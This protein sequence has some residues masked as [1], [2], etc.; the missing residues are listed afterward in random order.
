[1]ARDIKDV[2]IEKLQLTIEQKEVIKELFGVDLPYQVTVL[3]E[4]KDGENKLLVTDELDEQEAADATC[5]AWC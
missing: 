2:D 3:K 4:K 5:V 1:M